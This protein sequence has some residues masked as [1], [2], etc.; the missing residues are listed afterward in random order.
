[1]RVPAKKK[2]QADQS[3][4]DVSLVIRGKSLDPDAV[5]EALGLRPTEV[6]RLGDRFPAPSPRKHKDSGWRLKGKPVA[7]FNLSKHV[8]A[9]VKQLEPY[10][11]R[12]PQLPE[13]ASLYV[14]CDV[15]D[16]EF[17]KSNL[18]LSRDA[19]A[20]VSK[21][22]AEIDIDYYDLSHGNDEE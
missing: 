19:V 18:S 8:E 22:G 11:E 6:W 3:H 15:C 7:G 17:R 20:G 14:Q 4:M 10:A 9:L 2:Q 1:M 16:Y 13:E 21:L 12:F 5:S